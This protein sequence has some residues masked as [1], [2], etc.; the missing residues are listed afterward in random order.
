MDIGSVDC[1]GVR[2]LSNSLPKVVRPKYFQ[3]GT[4]MVP[5]DYTE[6]V[7]HN[8]RRY[9]VEVF[10]IPLMAGSEPF[11]RGGWS[12]LTDKSVAKMVSYPCRYPRKILAIF[13][14]DTQTQSVECSLVQ[15]PSMDQLSQAGLEILQSGVKNM[16]AS[17]HCNDQANIG[18]VK[19][20]DIMLNA[21][22]SNDMHFMSVH[23]PR[24]E[25]KGV[26]TLTD[27]NQVT[28]GWETAAAGGPS[29]YKKACA[30]KLTPFR[31]IHI[32]EFCPLCGFTMDRPELSVM[33]SI[34]TITCASTHRVIIWIVETSEVS[35]I[36]RAIYQH[37]YIYGYPEITY[38]AWTG[39]VKTAHYVSNS[40]TTHGQ[41]MAKYRTSPIWETIRKWVVNHRLILD[42]TSQDDLR[43]V[44]ET[45]GCLYRYS[46]QDVHVDRITTSAGLC[47]VLDGQL[48]DHVVRP[49]RCDWLDH[50]VEMPQP[51]RRGY[52]IQTNKPRLGDFVWF[53]DTVRYTSPNQFYTVTKSQVVWRTG[54]IC[55][56]EDHQFTVVPIYHIS[57]FRT[58]G[59]GYR[60]PADWTIS[61]HTVC[62]V[63][64]GI[65][66]IADVD[67]I[68][69][70]PTQW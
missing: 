23:T 64:R 3:D 37:F 60:H 12:H 48:L 59:R 21:N 65:H 22:P 66:L 70:L 32:D 15:L 42:L 18:Q 9:W 24:L 51:I 10:R 14:P 68:A 11:F 43:T 2:G 69:P 4:T 45:I 13:T 34:L 8:P 67:E 58:T 49:S 46:P 53:K 31:A 1:N 56:V 41:V 55:E 16:F 20:T 57:Y 33:F 26:S 30:G 28:N 19:P 63:L 17:W 62:R 6:T 27:I 29:R 52:H 50:I 25:E 47:A 44:R 7:A 5:T 35:S 39:T 38:V 36:V 40:I 54:R 61:R